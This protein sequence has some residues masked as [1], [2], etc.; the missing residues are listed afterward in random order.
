MINKVVL[1]NLIKYNGIDC[2]KAEATS[3]TIPFVPDTDFNLDFIVYPTSIPPSTFNA[4][5]AEISGTDY[6]QIRLLDTGILFRT[7]LSGTIDQTI[8]VGA[9]VL[10][11]EMNISLTRAGD[12]FT[13]E[14]DGA[15]GTITSAVRD[16]D[17]SMNLSRNAGSSMYYIRNAVLNSVSYINQGDF[18]SNNLPSIPSGLDGELNGAMWWKQ[19]VDENFDSPTAPQD[20]KDTLKL[21]VEV[22]DP[23]Q[24]VIY[25]DATPYYPTDDPFW[26]PWNDNTISFEVSKQSS[27]VGGNLNYGSMKFSLG[28]YL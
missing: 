28:L 16:T 18:G 2:L 7:Y 15:D 19:G 23:D 4:F 11:S 8:V 24:N 14:V 21:P 12:V 9:T 10:D 26:N 22:G 25:T 6:W 1:G 5:L 3:C 13:I 17:T 20:Y 27:G